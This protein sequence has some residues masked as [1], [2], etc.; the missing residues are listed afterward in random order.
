MEKA[1][2]IQ[3]KLLLSSAPRLRQNPIKVHWNCGRQNVEQFLGGWSRTE[4]PN[5]LT[6]ISD[7]ILAK[8]H[9]RCTGNAVVIERVNT[10]Q[11]RCW[12]LGDINRTHRCT[13]VTRRNPSH[14]HSICIKKENKIARMWQT[15]QHDDVF[16]GISGVGDV[17]WGAPSK[18][19]KEHEG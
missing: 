1:G 9:V 6:N 19:H 10:T 4:Q 13:M 11:R 5:Q 16:A 15:K 12:D 14:S 8:V 17:V 7:G 18:P 2:R 3:R